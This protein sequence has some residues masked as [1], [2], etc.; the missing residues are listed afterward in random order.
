M[1][2]LSEEYFKPWNSNWI[3]LFTREDIVGNNAL[4]H[5]ALT[6]HHVTGGVWR[7]MDS[8]S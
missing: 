7:M 5:T 1:P 2:G 8:T 4:L 3:E 6:Y